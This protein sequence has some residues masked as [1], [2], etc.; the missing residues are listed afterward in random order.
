MTLGFPQ[1]CVG[2]FRR[3]R[4]Y[5]RFKNRL[6]SVWNVNN[7]AIPPGCEP[8]PWPK[9]AKSNEDVSESS[10]AVCGFELEEIEGLLFRG[11]GH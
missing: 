4:T 8:W 2:Q 11:M 5:L 9:K 3:T 1:L 6:S 10:K 7:V